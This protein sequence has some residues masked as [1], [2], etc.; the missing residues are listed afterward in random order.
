MNDSDYGDKAPFPAQQN[1]IF[2]EE[3]NSIYYIVPKKNRF[4]DITSDKNQ[5]V[6]TSI[7]SNESQTK[8]RSKRRCGS[9]SG[10][11]RVLVRK[12]SCP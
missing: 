10:G 3:Q 1:R 7:Y 12:D 4:L 11:L 6:S 2:S 9:K 5:Y 8:N